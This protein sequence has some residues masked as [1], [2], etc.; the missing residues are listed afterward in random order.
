MLKKK[1]IN[2]TKKKHVKICKY[3]EMYVEKDF[4]KI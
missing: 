2:E 4:V 1:Q 3:I